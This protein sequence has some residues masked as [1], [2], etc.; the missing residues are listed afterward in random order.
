MNKQNTEGKHNRKKVTEIDKVDW[1]IEL[2]TND[3]CIAE[4][5]LAE[6]QKSQE[7]LE[8]HALEIR[9]DRDLVSMERE[10]ACGNR[11]RICTERESTC[12]EK[13]ME[14]KEREIAIA[15]KEKSYEE[16][17]RIFWGNKREIGVKR[18]SI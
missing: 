12:Q 5:T 4:Y 1:N 17:E 13:E 11:E 9:R 15:K 14:F 6:R 2:R 10:E 3:I 7:N 18:K 16:K 8:R